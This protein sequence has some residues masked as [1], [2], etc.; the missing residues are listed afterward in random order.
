MNKTK[1]YS[2]MTSADLLLDML[3]FYCND[4][5]DLRCA[6]TGCCR[7]SDIYYVQEL[8]HKKAD[9]VNRR[10]DLQFTSS[11]DMCN[12][13]EQAV[14]L[15]L[16]FANSSE[17]DLEGCAFGRLL[18]PED[19]VAVDERWSCGASAT[20]VID[21]YEKAPKWMKAK[22]KILSFMQALHDNDEYWEP[23]NNGGI[24]LSKNG[25]T[26]LGVIISTLDLN[27]YLFKKYNN[28]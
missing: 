3:D 16:A 6:F 25:S 21:E 24:K 14:D 18:P 13:D 20:T 11:W 15:R 27:E 1:N 8:T 19:A 12:E 9:F 22:N 26:Y 7:Y 23:T 2:K 17:I 4:T 28:E 10:T 5:C